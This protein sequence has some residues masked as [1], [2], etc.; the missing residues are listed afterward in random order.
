ML[1][2]RWQS[3]YY[4]DRELSVD[5]TIIPFKGHT[6]MKVYKPNKPHKWGLNCWNLAEA[7]TGYIWNSELYKGKR[8]NETEV[9]L[10]TTVVTNLCEP[11]YDHGHHVYMDNLFSSPQLYNCLGE[12]GV[13]AC[14]TLRING[15]GTPEQI[16]KSKLKKG[17]PYFP[18]EMA[19]LS[20][21]HGL[22][23]DRSMSCQPCTMT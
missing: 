3:A 4:P 19:N 18:C 10:Y 6:R 17:I 11:M 5:E 21:C 1:V 7:K 16:K 14:G 15:I 20:S 23:N 8:S 12:H 13:G 2:E 9:G 22:T